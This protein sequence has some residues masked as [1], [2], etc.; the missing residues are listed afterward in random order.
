[1][2][3]DAMKL[4][5]S[6][7]A[8]DSSG[9]GLVADRR[10]LTKWLLAVYTGCAIAFALLIAYYRLLTTEESLVHGSFELDGYECRPLTPDPEY[11][12]T[13]T[14]D[15]C[16]EKYYEAPTTSNLI[17]YGDYGPKSFSTTKIG[18]L[19]YHWS[20]DGPWNMSETNSQTVSPR[21]SIDIFTVY[22]IPFPSLTNQTFT[23]N[24]QCRVPYYKN[25]DKHSAYTL[26][27]LD[28]ALRTA[29]ERGS[30]N[31]EGQYTG[32]GYYGLTNVDF[33]LSEDRAS[34]SYPDPTANV[35]KLD[36]GTN[37]VSKC[38]SAN[39]SSTFQSRVTSD[40][41][42][43][44]PHGFGNDISIWQSST[45]TWDD[46]TNSMVYGD[47]SYLKMTKR[48]V[49][50][51]P[52]Y[53]V[54]PVNLN[55]Y[56]PDY[57]AL[58]GQASTE[59]YMGSPRCGYYEKETSRQAFEYIYSLANCHPCDSFKYNSPFFCEKRTRKTT[60]EILTLASSNIM[61][62]W[63]AMIALIPFVVLIYTKSKGK[64]TKLDRGEDEAPAVLP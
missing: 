25:F 38:G 36:E 19:D 24:D 27:A 3:L 26:S 10:A 2:S 42:Y 56:R 58:N 43:V 48:S 62:V 54:V 23:Y 11:G 21:S 12:L 47:I 60:A 1:M 16:V 40:G 30:L 52:L 15:E 61:A 53:P 32:Y 18:G 51:T 64:D 6:W 37:F 39:F 31:P 8:M 17:S 29:V 59:T 55:D 50:M 20:Y 13:I 9:A 14:Y 63:G 41:T 33:Q 5:Q 34:L 28:D 46:T 4:P 35:F 57:S 7:Y 45:A 44:F 49:G 22:H